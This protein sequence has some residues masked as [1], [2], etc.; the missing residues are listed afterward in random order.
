MTFQTY[1]LSLL[2]KEKMNKILYI[3]LISFLVSLSSHVV[4]IRKSPLLILQYLQQYLL[5]QHHQQYPQYLPQQIIKVQYQ[6]TDNITVTFSEAMHTRYITTS[7]SDT[8]CAG[9]IRVSSDN[10]VLVL[11]CP[12]DQDGS[13][14][15]IPT[16]HLHWI[17]LTISLSNN[18]QNKS[19]NWS[20][21]YCR[22]HLSSQ[23]ETST[24]FT[25]S[26]PHLQEYSWELNFRNHSE[27]KL[28]VGQLG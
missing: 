6:I 19:Y 11:K 10:S 16:K 18:L 2:V 7:T 4:E 17:H 24:G 14:D 25:T 9:T 23:Y 5:I 13:Q 27:I 28:T 15:P 20:K 21:R 22:E 12:L 3:V 8:N 26:P 1:F